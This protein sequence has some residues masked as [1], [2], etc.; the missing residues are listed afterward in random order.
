[1]TVAER[2]WYCWLRG[3]DRGGWAV[4]PGPGDAEVAICR[5]EEVAR[6]VAAAPDLLA[7]CREALTHPALPG[8]LR[9][10]IRAAIARAT[11]QPTDP[12]PPTRKGWSPGHE[13]Q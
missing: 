6:L 11:D 12:P 13:Y 10:T 8:S 2:P 7:A 3:E 5:S 4:G 1:M 9:D